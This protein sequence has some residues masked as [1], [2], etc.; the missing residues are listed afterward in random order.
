MV[1]GRTCTEI[2]SDR[3]SFSTFSTYSLV[4]KSCYINNCNKRNI[5]LCTIAAFHLLLLLLPF[6]LI[7]ILLSFQYRSIIKYILTQ[8]RSSSSVCEE[9]Q[10]MAYVNDITQSFRETMKDNIL[11]DCI[12]TNALYTKYY[13]YKKKKFF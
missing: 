13:F 2:V 4:L 11:N 6:F 7:T 3:T 5:V 10:K 1:Q 9:R 8:K 12:I